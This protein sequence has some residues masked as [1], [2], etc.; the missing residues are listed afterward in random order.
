MT[1]S[2]RDDLAADIGAADL[3]VALLMDRVIEPNLDQIEEDGLAEDIVLGL[4]E[5]LGVSVVVDSASNRTGTSS[6]R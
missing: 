4:A 5:A 1:T 6:G 2:T 3:I